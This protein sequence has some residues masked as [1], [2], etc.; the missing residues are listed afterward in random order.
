[1]LAASSMLA[2]EEALER[3]VALAR[4]W[5]AGS[6]ELRAAISL[7]RLRSARGEP[8]RAHDLLAPVYARFA[9][10]VETPDRQEA[11]RLLDMLV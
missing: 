11:K 2:A 3:A 6:L 5:R 4:E 8:R 9:E 7:A 1:M 10:D